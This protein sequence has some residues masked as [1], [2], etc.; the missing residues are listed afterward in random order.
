MRLLPGKNQIELEKSP[1]Y[2]T[3]SSAVLTGGIRFPLSSNPENPID[4][5]RDQ[6]D[7][8]NLRKPIFELIANEIIANPADSPGRPVDAT[9]KVAGKLNPLDRVIEM[10]EISLWSGGGNLHGAGS[11]GFAGETPSL[12]IALTIPKMSVETAKTNL[13]NIYRNKARRWVID[14]I[15]GGE[16]TGARI[17]AA[18]PSGI[19]G[20]LREGKKLTP[21]QLSVHLNVAGATIKTIGEMP[22]I[23][24]A[25]GTVLYQG[26]ETQ[27]KLSAGTIQLKNG[28]SVDAS[29]GIIKYW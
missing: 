29:D 27:I 20:R 16:V 12:A 13:A 19:L 4:N 6:I 2:F 18:I 28:R 23:E 22:A 5:K 26:M 24:Q 17:D 8:A 14:H 15:S 11:F 9:F 1:V 25:S 3:K 7:A 21:E 10:E